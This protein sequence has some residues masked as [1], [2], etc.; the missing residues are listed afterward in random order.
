MIQLL[1]TDLARD[2]STANFTAGEAYPVWSPYDAFEAAE[3][4][5]KML[6]H[7]GPDS[8]RFR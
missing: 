6:E 3:T 4:L 1:T 2:E 8:D 7:S 5:R